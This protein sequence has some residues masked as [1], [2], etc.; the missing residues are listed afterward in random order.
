MTRV[1]QAQTPPQQTQTLQLMLDLLKGAAKQKQGADAA[2]AGDLLEVIRQTG[3]AF[4]V[5]AQAMKNN[6]LV[7]SA[8]ALAKVNNDTAAGDIDSLITGIETNLPPRV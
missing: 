2:A 7:T 1:W 4:E 6:S 3:G 5:A 8:R